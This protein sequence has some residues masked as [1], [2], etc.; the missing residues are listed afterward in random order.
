MKLT[1]AS[2]SEARINLLKAA[3]INFQTVSPN[4]DEDPIM[5]NSQ[6][7]ASQKVSQLSALK[8]QSVYEIVQDHDRSDHTLWVVGGDTL[9]EID[10][11]IW[12]KPQNRDQAHERLKF[13]S[14]KTGAIYSGLTLIHQ[15]QT[16]TKIA[17][18]QV[19]M[20]QMSD[21]EIEAYLK[22]PEPMNAAGN[23]AIEG[24][25]GPFIESISGDYFAIIGLSLNH[26]NQALHELG[27]SITDFWQ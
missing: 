16:V 26:L 6:L 7:S 14:G 17:L 20:S 8:A 1:L 12:G 19:T 3:H 10:G 15:N 25:G 21:S 22:T 18:A 23:F 24:F 9:F 13:M 27:H 2:T 11:Q 5:Q 4:A